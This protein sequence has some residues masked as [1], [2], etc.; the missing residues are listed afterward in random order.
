MAYLQVLSGPQ[1]AGRWNPLDLGTWVVGRDNGTA[2]QL[3][4][5]YISKW[6]FRIIRERPTDH[7]SIEPIERAAPTTVG[8]VLLARRRQL[9]IGDQIQAGNTILCLTAD[10]P[11]QTS[12]DPEL[13]DMGAR[14][15]Q[16]LR[17]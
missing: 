7:F 17:E 9:D 10:Q 8:G 1:D 15:E 6:Q 11:G 2:F 12:E 13:K 5:R 3:S 4:D 14:D 16:T